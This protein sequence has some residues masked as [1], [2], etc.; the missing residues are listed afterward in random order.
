MVFLSI[1]S[2]ILLELLV[3]IVLIITFSIVTGNSMLILLVFL[4]LSKVI[5]L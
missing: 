2:I 5:R 4:H 3:L 1:I